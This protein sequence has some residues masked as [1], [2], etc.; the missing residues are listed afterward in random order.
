[1]IFEHSQKIVFWYSK[2]YFD[3]RYESEISILIIEILFRHSNWLGKCYFDIRN[4]TLTFE[5]SRKMLFWYSKSYFDIRT[6][7]E[8]RI[9]TFEILLWHSN[10]VGKFVIWHSISHFHIRTHSENAIMIFKILFW[11]SNWVGKSY[12]DIQNPIL[13]FHMSGKSYFLCSG[14]YCF[15]FVRPPIRPPVRPYVRLPVTLF[16]LLSWKRSDGYSSIS[17]DTLIS[18]RYNH[19]RKK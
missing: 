6:E 8:N 17:A 13:T 7:S 16:F 2:S 18:I 10:W 9:L 11:Y 14:V 19:I 12:F 3:I 5:L 4:P 15:H 1:M